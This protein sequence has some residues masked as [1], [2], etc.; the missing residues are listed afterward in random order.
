MCLDKGE[1]IFSFKAGNQAEKNL[2]QQ[3][4]TFPMA[5]SLLFSMK[6]SFYSEIRRESASC[7]WTAQTRRKSVTLK[8]DISD[9][10][11]L[12]MREKCIVNN[13]GWKIPN[14]NNAGDSQWRK[15][16]TPVI[17]IHR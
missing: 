13:I 17:S 14:D 6:I 5:F 2:P 7:F 11:S 15:R 9:S 12:K 3:A 8:N 1:V 10:F 16:N 4:D